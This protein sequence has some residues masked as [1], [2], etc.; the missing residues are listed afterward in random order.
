MK[1]LHPTLSASLCAAVLLVPTAYSADGATKPVVLQPDRPDVKTVAI[2][3]V[4]APAAVL[5]PADFLSATETRAERTSSRTGNPSFDL[6]DHIVFDERPEGLWALARGWKAQFRTDG[7]TFTPFFGS[8]APRSAPITF[9]LQS[10]TAGERI[11]AVTGS[12]VSRIGNDVRI[13]RGEVDEGYTARPE[14]LEQLFF[15]DERLDADLRLAIGVTGDYTLSQDKDG[16]RFENE[17]GSVRYGRARAIDA[18]GNTVDVEEHLVD[19]GIEL[20]VPGTWLA[21]A[22]YPVTVDPLIGS[23]HLS[24]TAGAHVVANDIAFDGLAGVQAVVYSRT[25]DFVDSDV[26]V[27]LADHNGPVGSPIAIDVSQVWWGAASVAFN[28]VGAC[29]LVASQVLAVGNDYV[30][31]TRTVQAATSIVGA[32]TML[33]TTTGQQIRPVIGGDPSTVAPS[34]FFVAYV[35]VYS[36]SDQDVFG[37]LVGSNGTPVGTAI[38]LDNSVNT[39][40]SHLSISKSDGMGSYLTQKWALVWERPYSPSDVDI[41]GMEIDWNGSVVKPTFAINTSSSSD[42]SPF[43]SSPTDERLGSRHYVATFLREITTPSFSMQTMADVIGDGVVLH[44]LDIDAARGFSG[45]RFEPV[46]DCDGRGF[47]VAAYDGDNGVVSDIE[48][49]YLSLVDGHLE[50]DPTFPLMLASTADFDVFPHV[51]AEHSG[52]STSTN[53]AFAWT[54]YTNQLQNAY[55]EGAVFEGPVGGQVMNYCAGYLGTCPCGSTPNSVGGCSN[56]ADAAGGVLVAAGD[57]AVSADSL[58][59][60]ALGMPSNT[61]ALFFQGTATQANGF[62]TPFGDGLLCVGGTIV[63]LGVRFA[64][65]GSAFHP[66]A[67]EPSLSVQGLIPATGGVRY[68]QAW[69]RDAANFCTSATFNLTDAL[70]IAWVM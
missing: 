33:P 49:S 64:S 11:L 42:T 58:Q 60:Q 51:T 36:S 65:G 30:I 28:R 41:Y 66:A 10:A 17:L 61:A 27:Q 55:L 62:G 9:A 43:V 8:D 24:T 53:F 52:G 39:L 68:Y 38:P 16:I 34:Y 70:R 50:Y 20:I 13:E 21:R 40:D 67:G 18:S 7:T 26:L 47:A 15:V 25:F 37:Q 46:V 56:S 22:S 1:S 45:R 3:P 48:L 44:Q 14:A 69:F 12:D 19:G 54:R 59:L 23:Y 32:P 57:A 2:A 4:K 6:A 5:P 63:R 35:R 31:M 29:F